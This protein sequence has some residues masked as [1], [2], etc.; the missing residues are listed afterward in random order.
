M[1]TSEIALYREGVN[2]LLELKIDQQITN[3][4]P[5]HASVLFEQFFK[6]SQKQV[7][8]FCKNMSAQVFDSPSVIDAAKNAINRGVLVEV[9]LQED[10]PESAEMNA[11]AKTGRG[12]VIHKAVNDAVR[13]APFNFTVMDDRA[14]RFE[15]DRNTI[16]AVA[17]MFDSKV[18]LLLIRNFE[19]MQASSDKLELSAAHA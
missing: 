2:K 11:L 18:A 4:F 5:E 17:N 13:E 9:V 15:S 3:G 7:R 8:I 1:N 12:L 10:G 19:L 14:Y 16:K 6:H